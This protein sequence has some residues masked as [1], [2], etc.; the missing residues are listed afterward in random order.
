MTSIA[1][2]VSFGG[3]F[4]EFKYINGSTDG[5]SLF[6]RWHQGSQFC[7]TRGPV[8]HLNKAFALQVMQVMFEAG[9][10]NMRAN[11]TIF[12]KKVACISQSNI[13]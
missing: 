7:E 1:Q 12:T 9:R 13:V 2:D 3:S 11:L 6:C 10:S 5:C 4:S 8:S